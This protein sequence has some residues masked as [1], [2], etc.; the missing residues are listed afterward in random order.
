[1]FDPE[2]RYSATQALEHSYL[3][4]SG[5][6]FQN[7]FQQ[8]HSSQTNQLTDVMTSSIPQNTV[9]SSVNS[10]FLD[11]PDATSNKI[12]INLSTETNQLQMD[13]SDNDVK[14]HMNIVDMND[15]TSID[16]CSLSQ[17]LN[18]HGKRRSAGDSIQ[19]DTR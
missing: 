12:E 17:D 6:H 11:M 1:M 16:S 9:T 3:T 8:S 4:S 13:M 19:S 2:L 7:S 10:T 14:N 5:F 18:G 15:L